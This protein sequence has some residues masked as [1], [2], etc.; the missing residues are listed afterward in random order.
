M[1]SVEQKLEKS[2]WTVISVLRTF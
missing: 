1:K 2:L